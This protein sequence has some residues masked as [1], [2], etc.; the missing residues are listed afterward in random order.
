MRT[1]TLS[2]TLLVSLSL[3]TPSPHS[4]CLPASRSLLAAASLLAKAAEL[5][6]LSVGDGQSST[7]HSTALFLYNAGLSGGELQCQADISHSVD[8]EGCPLSIS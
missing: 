3:P 5:C 8:R 1:T 2:P 6:Y 7:Q 4:L